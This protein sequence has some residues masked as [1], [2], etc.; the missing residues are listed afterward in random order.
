M[1]R[2]E[3]PALVEERRTFGYNEELKLVEGLNT[4]ARRGEYK[5]SPFKLPEFTKVCRRLV[6]RA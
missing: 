2:R 6:C 3:E 1:G 5:G 4:P